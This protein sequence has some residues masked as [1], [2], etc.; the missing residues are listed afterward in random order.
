VKLTK[1]EFIVDYILPLL[2]QIG[3]KWQSGKMKIS[4]EHFASSLI[5]STL[6]QM[7]EIDDESNSPKV[8]ICTPKNQDHELMALAI[9]VL[10]STQ[11]FRVIYIGSSVPAEEISGVLLMTDAIAL[12]LSITYPKDDHQLVNQLKMIEDY[13]DKDTLLIAGGSAAE[14]YIQKLDNT[15]FTYTND[16]D[17]LFKMLNDQREKNFQL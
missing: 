7:I 14:N 10:V 9:A 17:Q 4:N 2:N 1:R 3:T 12:I 13:S 11:G 5:Y 15:Q 8:V 6:M 16:I